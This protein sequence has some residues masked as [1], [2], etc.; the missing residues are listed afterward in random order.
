M[1]VV[2]RLVR[3]WTEPV[4]APDEALAAFSEAYTDPVSINGV[5][6][7]LA[8]LVARA[9]GLQ[10]AFADLRIELIEQIETPGRVVIAFWQRGRHVGPLESPLGEISPTGREVEIR[11]IDVLSIT[12]GRIGAIQVVP[13]NLGLAM[14]LGAVQLVQRR[15]LP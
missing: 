5:E 13:D 11:V 7:P 6:V 15:K 8:D 14:Q 3:L 2:D 1:S 4:A 12:D 9:R 10:R